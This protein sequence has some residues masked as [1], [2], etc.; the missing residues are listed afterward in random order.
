MTGISFFN[1]DNF[2]RNLVT[3]T[4][5]GWGRVPIE[6]RRV[7]SSPDLPIDLDDVLYDLRVD[8]QDDPAERQSVER[9]FRTAAGYIERASACVVCRGTF[10]VMLPSFW[11]GEL[12]VRRYPLREIVALEALTAANTWTE[13]PADKIYAES[14][15]DAFR[16]QTLPSYTTPTLWSEVGRVR[17]RFDAGFDDAAASGV[18]GDGSLPIQEPFRGIVTAMTAHLYRNRELLDADKQSEVERGL[19]SLLGS[20]RT[21]W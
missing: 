19:G 7:A 21:L 16:L 20:I 10:E 6:V 18:S 2:I 5:E 1:N 11:G 8:D 13:V 15:A 14:G 9:M 3:V 4:C 12:E 17:L